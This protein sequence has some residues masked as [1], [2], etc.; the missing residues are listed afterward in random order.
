MTTV[1]EFCMSDILDNIFGID[2]GTSNCCIALWKNGTYTIIKD[3]Y[4][5]KTIPSI[6]GITNDKKY[7]GNDVLLRND[8]KSENIFYGIKRLIGKGYSEIENIKNNFTY[9]IKSENSD[10]VII[11]GNINNE[12]KN[13]YPEE[14]TAYILQYIK[15]CI[16]EYMKISMD[17]MPMLK[18]VVTIPAYFNDSQ[19]QST[20]DAIKIAGFDCLKILNEP[21]AAAMAYG[22]EKR[23]KNDGLEHIIMVYDMGG[24]TTDVSILNICDGVFEVLASTGNTFL[25][26]IDFD[27]VL[28]K[29]CVE[30]FGVNMDE[31]NLD[32][33]L[34]L[35]NKCEDTK[36]KI[37][38]DE[39]IL[40]NIKNF[41]KNND[42]NVLITQTIFESLSEKLLQKSI[43]PIILALESC[44]LNCE[45]I[46]DIIMVG[47]ATKMKL[48]KNKISK[49]FNKKLICN[50]NP[51]E[52]VAIGAAIQGF[53]LTKKTDPFTD[54]IVLLDITPLSLGVEVMGGI[55]DVIIKRNTIIPTTKNK[56]YTNDTDN[57][58][59]IKIKIFEG[60]R[61]MTKNNIFMGELILDNISPVP[62]GCAD[63]NIIFKIDM[64][65]LISV[66]AH[67]LNNGIIQHVNI[68]LNKGRLSKEQIDKIIDDAMISEK[69]DEIEKK[70]TNIL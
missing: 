7:V 16:C 56:K 5:N 61:P 70:K 58:T 12:K 40:I 29:Y 3:E 23:Y 36:K 69:K 59:S 26:G 2:L 67:E 17:V 31:I 45:D 62:R 37:S 6:V 46:N 15:K 25:G 8:I 35:K 49:I 41:H 22:Y 34:I 28:I 43:E 55:M 9:E 63:I 11:C 32:K 38:I 68:T 47:G 13:Y 39:N 20:S 30:T 48:L 54:N 66:T 52:V 4:K 21:T 1:N 64:N 51:D 44:E 10:N 42:L 14:I 57:E 65:G 24:G 33:M 60:E 50:I 27:N 18:V 19:R 53:I